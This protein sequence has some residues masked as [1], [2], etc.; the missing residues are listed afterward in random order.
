MHE[1]KLEPPA[2]RFFKKRDKQDQK[3]IISKLRNL[4]K[5]PE[6]GKPLT[7]NLTG[8]WTIRFGKFRALYIIKR[9]EL[10]I[11]KLGHRK[12]IYG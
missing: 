1:V 7:A 6:L 2:E 11:L 9:N 10:I 5:N 4:E 8:L 3:R 12:K